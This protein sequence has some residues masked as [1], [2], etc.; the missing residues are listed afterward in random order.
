MNILDLVKQI[1]DTCLL[2]N[3]M[4]GEKTGLTTICQ[5]PG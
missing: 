3:I 1:H 2:A 4:R 5:K